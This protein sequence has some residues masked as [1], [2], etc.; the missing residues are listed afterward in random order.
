MCSTGIFPVVDLCHILLRKGLLHAHFPVLY[1]QQRTQL[2][3]VHTQQLQ[4][5][6][7]HLGKVKHLLDIHG[8][9]PKYCTCDF[10][11]AEMKALTTIFPEV[12]LV[13]CFYHFTHALTTKCQQFA[14][15]TEDRMKTTKAMLFALKG[16]AFIEPEKIVEKFNETRERFSKFG[17]SYAR[18]LKY[19]NSQ[20][21]IGPFAIHKWNYNAMIKSL[22][23]NFRVVITNN[24]VEAI[25]S[26]LNAA[27]GSMYP[28]TYD[29]I[30]AIKVVENMKKYHFKKQMEQ[31]PPAWKT[32]KSL[33]EHY[34]KIAR[35]RGAE[36]DYFEYND[37]KF[38][39]LDQI[40]EMPEWEGES[41]VKTEPAGL[42][43][44]IKE[45]DQA[46]ERKFWLLNTSQPSY[47]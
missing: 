27:L 11:K 36:F 33:Y 35:E 12:R 29:A 8:V 10:E 18:F 31:R 17:D 41:Q 43:A 47:R 20:F 19:F 28:T 21:I 30:Q 37:E 3:H 7:N 9:K 14:L 26:R 6:S 38:N 13:S 39:D 40:D 16:L 4:D 15:Y 45:E 42:L 22:D 46:R 25:N 5:L 2:I 1:G 23:K 24:G 34:I 32:H 44:P